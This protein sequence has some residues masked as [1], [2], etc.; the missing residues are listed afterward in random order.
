MVASRVTIKVAKTSWLIGGGFFGSVGGSRSKRP[1]CAFSHRVFCVCVCAC[2]C[3]CVGFACMH[4]CM[5]VGTS[6]TH[7]HMHVFLLLQAHGEMWLQGATAR[8]D[9][10]AEK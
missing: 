4:A 3:V 6:N 7:A 1:L 8:L 5:H 10:L 2:V 9:R